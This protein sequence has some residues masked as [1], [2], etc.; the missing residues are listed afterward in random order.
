M[1]ARLENRY[2]NFICRYDKFLEYFVA[3]NKF[4]TAKNMYETSF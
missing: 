3:T 2:L 1:E 4:K